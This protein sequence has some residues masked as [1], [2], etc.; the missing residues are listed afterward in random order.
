MADAVLNEGYLLDPHRR[1]SPDSHVRGQFG[2][3]APR[4]WVDA[5]PLRDAGVAGSAESWFQQAHCLVEAGA[6]A[7]VHVQVRFLHL[8]RQRPI[9]RPLGGDV[10]AVAAEDG[11]VSCDQSVPH[12]VDAVAELGSLLAREQLLPIHVAGGQTSDETVVRTRSP[13]TAMLRLR[14]EIAHA[15]FPLLRLRVRLSNTARLHD[16]AAPRDEALRHSLL[17]AHMLIK[18]TPG[19]FLSLLDPPEWAADAAA[20]CVNQHVFPVLAGGHD[21][22]V[23]CSPITRTTGRARRGRAGASAHR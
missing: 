14:A 8:Q 10:A 16:A 2:V 7:R 13:V 11:E 15:P 20:S 19:R 3:V 1:S 4:N 9:E 12:H 23:L 6:S 21:H 5:Q 17:G 22:I 18:V